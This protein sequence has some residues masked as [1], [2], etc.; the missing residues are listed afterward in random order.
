M[1]DREFKAEIKSGL[2]GGYLIYGEEEY[3]KRRLVDAAVKSVVGDDD[4]SAVN[5]VRTDADDYSAAALEDAVSLV[6]M[7]SDRCAAVCEVRF[8]DLKESEKE[9][10][11]AALGRLKDNPSCVLFLVVPAWYFEDANAKKGKAPAVPKKL[12]ALLKPVCV[13]YQPL[14]VLKPWVEKHFR[15]EGLS[16]GSDA[17]NYFVSLSGPDMTSLLCETDKLSCFVKSKGRTEVTSG[18]VS[19][20]CSDNTELDAFALSNAVVGGDREGALEALKECRDNKMKPT[21]V[22]ARMTSEFM[23]ML[24]VAACVKAG[25]YKQEISKKLGLHEFRVGKYMESV[26]DTDIDAIRTV[27]ARCVDVDAALKSSSA[28]GFEPLERFV[29]TIP[30]RKAARGYR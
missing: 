29:C 9:A 1:T 16:I 22:I 2:E 19:F 13:P 25:M 4:F 18:D 3:I 24:S 11:Y 7:M 20:V 8:T 30:S 15:A 14:P 21:A 5:V 28:T 12:E 26:R 17:L 27:I 23:N 10:M 6:P